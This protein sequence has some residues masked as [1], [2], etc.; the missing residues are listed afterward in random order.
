M[1][2][3]KDWDD[4]SEEYEVEKPGVEVYME[5]L[6]HGKKKKPM[7]EE[8]KQRLEQAKV[9][10]A[11]AEFLDTIPHAPWPSR[12]MLKRRVVL[13]TP[14][15]PVRN[16]V[17][18]IIYPSGSMYEG[19]VTDGKRHGLGVY[20]WKQVWSP[21]LLLLRTCST[22]LRQLP[23]QCR[24]ASVCM[25]VTSRHTYMRT[26]HAV[27]ACTHLHASSSQSICDHLAPTEAFAGPARPRLDGGR[28]PFEFQENA[29][30]ASHA[31]V[32]AIPFPCTRFNRLN[33]PTRAPFSTC[34]RAIATLECGLWG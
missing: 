24:G 17:T 2:L 7:S 18:R 15:I 13:G 29:L 25:N 33:F 16:G 11:G 26:V 1:S 8:E 9:V 3:F 30:L 34:H 14:E 28:R 6:K 10:V 19:E 5:Q 27:H 20:T 32:N 31:H 21:T 4:D 23:V 22:A 12:A